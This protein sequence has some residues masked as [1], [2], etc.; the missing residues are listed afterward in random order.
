MIWL[1]SEGY[2]PFLSFLQSTKI[3]STPASCAIYSLIETAKHNGLDLFPY[4]NYVFTKAPEID[5]E[6]AWD[7]LMPHWLDQATLA[8]ALPTALK[9]PAN[10]SPPAR[11]R[12][13]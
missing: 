13:Y 3:Y 5:D 11:V 2:A 1:L 9:Q 12:E 6:N 10:G 8:S 4:L 7:D